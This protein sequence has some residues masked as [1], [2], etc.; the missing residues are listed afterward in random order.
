[1]AANAFLSPPK[2]TALVRI[3]ILSNL[4]MVIVVVVVVRQK[5]WL[6]DC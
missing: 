1:M 5:A 2:R 3:A 6:T 4:V